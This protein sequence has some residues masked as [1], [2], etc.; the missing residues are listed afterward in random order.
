MITTNQ[1]EWVRFESSKIH[2]IGGYAVADIPKGTKVIEYL[3]EKISKAESQKRCKAGNPF[4][5]YL[6]EQLDLDG[7]V[8]W[9]MAR[10]LNHCCAPNCESQHGEGHIWLI[11]LLDI[12]EGEE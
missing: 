6:D 9:N 12:K 8:D 5:F 10:H 2:G 1:T 4:V 3:G 7:S 11:A